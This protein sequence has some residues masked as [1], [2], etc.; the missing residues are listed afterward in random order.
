[1]E[2]KLPRPNMSPEARP[3]PAVQPE[4]SPTST[5]M[6]PEKHESQEQAKNVISDDSA[7]TAATQAAPASSVSLPVAQPAAPATTDDNSTAHLTANDEDRIEKEWVDKAKKVIAETREDPH[8]QSYEVSKMQTDYL[9]KRF[10]KQIN[11]PNDS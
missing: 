10:G 3:Q 5:E 6:T 8:Q 4:F 7:L 2:P 11:L 1:M 9:S